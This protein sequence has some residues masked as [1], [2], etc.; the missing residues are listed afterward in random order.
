VAVLDVLERVDRELGALTVLITYNAGI[1]AVADRVIRLSDGH[2]VEVAR[3]PDNRLLNPDCPFG[4]PL[5]LR[6][7]ADGSR[8]GASSSAIGSAMPSSQPPEPPRAPP[9]HSLASSW[10]IWVETSNDPENLG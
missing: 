3:N 1:H 9:R 2:I 5:G 6:A 4:G 8:P 7:L 10:T